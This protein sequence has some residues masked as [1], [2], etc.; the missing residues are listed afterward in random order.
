[1]DY[2]IK[3]CII[4]KHTEFYEHLHRFYIKFNKKENFINYKSKR[5]IF[6]I[7]L[8]QICSQVHGKL[9]WKIQIFTSNLAINF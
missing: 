1:M 2:L 5:K 7:Y 9:P 3:S 4:P 8:K 6:G